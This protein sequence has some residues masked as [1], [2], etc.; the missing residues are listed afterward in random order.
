MASLHNPDY[1][2]DQLNE[3]FDFLE[4]GRTQGPNESV[5]QVTGPA[6]GANPDYNPHLSNLTS[7]EPGDSMYEPKQWKAFGQALE[8]VPLTIIDGI[9]G[10]FEAVAEKAGLTSKG[11]KTARRM[12]AQGT[13]EKLKEDFT[14]GILGD[15]RDRE[16]YPGTY[17]LANTIGS[18][19]ALAPATAASGVTAGGGAIGRILSG[20]AQAAPQ[21]AVMGGILSPDGHRAEG[22]MEAAKWGAGI[23]AGLG[24]VKESARAMLGGGRS[25]LDMIRHIKTAKEGEKMSGIPA[26]TV[27]A[28]VGNPSLAGFESKGAF[29]KGRQQAMAEKTMNKLGDKFGV[30]KDDLLDQTAAKLSA[31]KA[32]A[33]RITELNKQSDGYYNALKQEIQTKAPNYYQNTNATRGAID[34]LKLEKYNQQGPLVGYAKELKDTPRMKID[35]LIGLRKRLSSDIN[36]LGRAKWAKGVTTAEK[37]ALDAEIKGLKLLETTTEY[38]LRAGAAATN[39]LGAFNNAQDFFR[40]NI[41]PARELGVMI[42]RGMISNFDWVMRKMSDPNKTS[43]IRRTYETLGPGVQAEFKHAAMSTAFG[44]GMLPGGQYKNFPAFAKAT[45]QTMDKHNMLFTTEDRALMEGTWKAAQYVTEGAKDSGGFSQTFATIW[46][47]TTS[48][49]GGKYLIKKMAG[50]DPK[51]TTFKQVGDGVN[52][53]LEVVRPSLYGNIVGGVRGVQGLEDEE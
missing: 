18:A 50:L 28:E 30:T 35:E 23:T 5:P 7:Y 20:A 51:S 52:D 38:N 46:N 49:P 19:A 40:D 32:G 13:F 9:H 45:K 21:A 47:L 6:E 8:H 16:A 24:V 3:A 15:K 11:N 34:T 1:D 25:P 14:P 43:E 2:P 33:M 17:K 29:G 39:T 31:Q 36:A 42:N 22:A 48:I 53:V 10:M 4:K 41:A 26:G 44:K 37:N 12:F 27:G